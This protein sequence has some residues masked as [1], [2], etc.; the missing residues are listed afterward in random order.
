VELEAYES[1]GKPWTEEEWVEFNG[2]ERPKKKLP[3]VLPYYCQQGY[4]PIDSDYC[5]N[6]DPDDRWQE[7][8][9]CQAKRV[10]KKKERDKKRLKKAEASPL[11]SAGID[12]VTRQMANTYRGSQ[13][14]DFSGKPER[15]KPPDIPPESKGEVEKRLSV[16]PKPSRKPEKA[17]GSLTEPKM[18]MSKNDPRFT[19]LSDMLAV[20]KVS[21]KSDL[22]ESN[23]S[24]KIIVLRGMLMTIEVPIVLPDQSQSSAVAFLDS[25]AQRS[26]IAAAYA[27]RLGLK[28]IRKEKV[29][30]TGFD[31]KTSRFEANIYKLKLASEESIEVESRSTRWLDV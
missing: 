11:T 10:L 21:A 27:K 7:I 28:P 4:R 29:A 13:A 2:P 9:A 26:F 6:M 24:G 19:K 30:I 5:Y 12:L 17:A 31:R 18:D 25:G 3:K 23:V 1:L 8:D 16:K 20:N 15:V 14:P 22:K